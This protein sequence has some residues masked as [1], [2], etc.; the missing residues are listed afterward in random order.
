LENNFN[1]NGKIS[2]LSKAD[3]QLIEK[4]WK[5]YLKNPSNILS[6]DEVKALIIKRKDL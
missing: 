6:W 5:D 4:R 1:L 2:E 3:I